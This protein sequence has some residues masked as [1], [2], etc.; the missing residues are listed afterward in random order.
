MEAPNNMEAE[1]AL[2][3]AI[4]SNNEALNHVAPL[5]EP[6][7]FYASSHQ[8][9][10]EAIIKLRDLGRPSTPITLKN[11][12]PEDGKYLASLMGAACYASQVHEYSLMIHDLAV[13]RMLIDIA[14]ET[15]EQACIMDAKAIEKLEEAEQKLFQVA[16]G[17]A[18][19]GD[20]V[21]VTNAIDGAL[22]TAE[23]AFK[24]KGQLSGITTGYPSLD[25]VINGMN[26]P[27]LLIVAGRPAM[28]KTALAVNITERAAQSLHDKKEDGCGGFFSLE[29]SKEQL[30]MR[31]IA[32][33]SSISSSRIQGGKVSSDEF[34]TMLE[35]SK[36][37]KSLP[38]HIEDTPAL[39]ISQIRAKARRLKRKKNMRFLVI[40]YLQLIRPSKSRGNRVEELS[41]ITQGLKAI[42]K[43]LHI[44]VIALSQLS[45]AV[46]AREDKR[47]QL[48]DLRE[49]G[50][51]EQDAD[52]V[53]FV[54]R[55][56]Y[57]LKRSEPKEGTTE[58]NAWQSKMM[59]CAGKADLIIAKHRNGATKSIPLMFKGETTQF[60][61]PQLF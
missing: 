13:R 34:Q 49:S 38:I 59:D 52:I 26:A 9:Y 36:L 46:E 19:E 54:Y 45:R 42:A 1:Q 41:E 37:I 48:A 14:G 29:M 15:I 22:Q 28:G 56:E 53:M 7:H 5:L 35:V 51:I 17:F 44:P 20:F 24:N 27:D 21:P 30:A 55:E 50:S 33:R 47:P 16:A 25:E 23:R 10:F 8:Y 43:E 4:L 12:F 57:Y 39:T 11:L 60:Y 31:M 61:E 2:L 58:Y 3:G 18:T 6:R 32:G 40:D